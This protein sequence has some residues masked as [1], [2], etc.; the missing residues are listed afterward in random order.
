MKKI[1][2]GVLTLITA[3]AYGSPTVAVGDVSPLKSQTEV[4]VKSLAGSIRNP[5][6]FPLANGSSLV[7]WIEDGAD[8]YFLRA[9]T[10]TAT[11]KLGAIQT[12]NSE[13]AAFL[14]RT[15]GVQETIAVN[16]SGQL[17]AVWATLGTRFSVPSQKIWGR[18]SLDGSSWS[19]PFVVI[20][21]LS[22]TGD[23]QMCMMEPAFTPRC[24]YIKLQAA[25][26]DKGRL[27][28]LVADNLETTGTRYRMKARSFAGKWCNF[29]TLSPVPDARTSEIVG[30]TSGFV[31]SATRYG[32]NSTNSVKT[33]YY[34]PKAEAWTSTLTPIVTSA[35]T[36]FKS[37]W[38]QR[39]LKNLTLVMANTSTGGG[40]SMRNF[41][42]DSKTWTS[43][44][45]TLQDGEPNRVVQDL[46]TA[47]VGGSLVVMFNVYD[48]SA[49]GFEV[50][51]AK[52]VGVTPTISAIGTSAEQVD[53][54]YVGSSLTSNAVIAY[55]HIME[56]TKLGGI[57]SSTLP[58]FIPNTATHSH[59]SAMAKTKSDKVLAAGLKFG[60]TTTSVIFTQGFVR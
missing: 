37:H 25:I 9:R 13:K 26:D 33:S 54:L 60:E 12:I 23:Q 41:N 24:G 43:N 57:N 27:A 8:G 39:D 10:V 38:V 44:L 3:F 11:N 56:G 55:S 45:I 46:S 18:T 53:L 5:K 35:N 40:L 6:V 28:V 7:T 15:E 47:K 51:V 59:L 42:V 17:F 21:G 22:V 32:G 20:P 2:V 48:Q 16:R 34:D 36:A 58:T 30:L 14:D 4:T 29:K 1:I 50:R 19:K 49:G 31:V 52:V